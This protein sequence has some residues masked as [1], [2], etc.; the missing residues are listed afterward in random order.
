MR[1][2]R[3]L[4]VVLF[5]LGSALV[6]LGLFNPAAITASTSGS[7]RYVASSC[8]GQPSPCYTTIQAAANAANDGDTI[9][10]AQGTYLETVVVSRS[11]TLEGGWKLG[12]T[13]RDWNLYTTTIDARRNGPVIRVNG[14]V[15]P[16][17]EGFSIT[18][19][20]ASEPWG[21]GGGILV[22]G[23]W[24]GVGTVTIRHNVVV[25]N[26]ACSE[27]SCQGYGGGI[28]VYSSRSVIEYN[29]VIS[30]LASWNGHLGG[31]GGGIAI[32]GWPGDA[33]IQ[34]N[35][36]ISNTALFS[37]TAEY[38]GGEGGGV[39]SD[40][41]VILT[42]NEIS[43]NVAAVQG[44]GRGGGVYAGGDLYNNR[45]ISNTASITGG[46]GYGGGVYAHYVPDFNDNLVQGNRASQGRDGSG[47]GVYAIYLRDAHQN[48]IVDNTATRGGGVYFQ[49]YTGQQ[50][51]ANNLVARNWAT[52]LDLVGMDGGGGIAT[53][54]DWVGIVGNDILSN[55]ALAGGG[56]R[57]TGGSRYLV[58]NNVLA[59]NVAAAGGGMFV[60][61]ATGTIAQNQVVGNHALWWGG[62]MYLYTQASPSMDANVVMSNT[63][64]GT[65]GAGGFA[66]GGIIVAVGPTTSIT[67]T[68]H[69]IARN[70]ILT[71]TAAGM[72]CL[73]GS[74]ALIH[75]TIVDNTLGSGRGEGVRISSGGLN[76]VRNSIIA[77]QGVGVN[78]VT[79]SATLDYNDYYDNSINVSGASPGTHS[80]ADNPQF[81]G[82]PVGDYHLMASSLL[83]DHGDVSVGVPRDFEG[84]PRLNGP[85]IGADEWVL[86]VY[87][88]LVL[89]DAGGGP[90]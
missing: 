44:E 90:H 54:A 72:H 85:D 71:G 11:V 24:A 42:D 81:A 47:G 20:D 62:G 58:Q 78:V 66:G 35:A 79:G 46:L 53:R 39:W 9:R 43:E 83:I 7:A 36:I 32:W 50:E 29:K 26:I 18:G 8:A 22:A 51:F 33:T 59:G 52:G 25:N 73:S 31:Q 75:D 77:G 17:I 55:T 15:S 89:R 38:A 70:N 76:V 57:V 67:L 4:L 49:D 5:G 40:H 65:G 3:L 34:H 48:T 69:I 23:T 14:E 19:G 88:P 84:D 80:R 68:N 10:V 6:L 41:D 30:N 56:V 64:W 74:C 60:Y 87:L 16:T 27:S 37:Q 45:I 28:M 61:S 1:L 13:E 2:G 21:W 82:R 86:R 12:F 63:A